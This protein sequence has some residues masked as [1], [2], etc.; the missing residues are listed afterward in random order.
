MS[1]FPSR[2]FSLSLGLLACGGCPLLVEP[3]PEFVEVLDE[4]GS[5]GSDTGAEG[6]EP[7][8]PTWLT[9]YTVGKSN[10]AL[11]DP[12]GPALL[13]AGGGGVADEALQW[14]AGLIDNGDIVI[15]QT[16]GDPLLNDYLYYTIGGA[17][18]VQTIIVPPGVASL[19]PWISWTLEHAEAVMIVGDEPY[20]LLWKDTPI[21]DAIMAAWQRGAVIGGY[22]AGISVLGEFLVPGYGVPLSSAE[23]LADPYAPNLALDRDYLSLELLGHALI[24]PRFAVEDRMGRLFAF[25]ARVLEEG[26]SSEFVGIGIDENTAMTIGHD[27]AAEVHGSGN[28]YLF[29]ATEPAFKCMPGKSLDFGPIEVHRLRAGDRATFPGGQTTVTGMLVEAAGGAMDPLDPY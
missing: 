12:G 10:D 21:E 29:R 6:D 2:A 23:A 28:V 24:E 16:A 17:D 14:Q 8:Q 25:A 22:D 4:S 15:L 5:A 18:S 13:L 1:S 3:N 7:V 19:D 26:W 11:A 27:G 20:G 9:V